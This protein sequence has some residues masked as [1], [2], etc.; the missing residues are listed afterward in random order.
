MLEWSIAWAG[1][2]SQQLRLPHHRLRLL[3]DFARHFI[4]I[5]L[6]EFW[7]EKLHGKRPRVTFVREF[8][9]DLCEWAY[10]VARDETRGLVEHFARH[11]RHVLKVDVRDLAGADAINIVELIVA[12]PKVVAVEENA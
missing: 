3:A 11:I 12:R 8:A 6:L 1:Q 5:A 7:Q 10:P 2:H 9:Q 4:G